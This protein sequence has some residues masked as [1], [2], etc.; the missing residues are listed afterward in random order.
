MQKQPGEVER[1]VRGAAWLLLAGAI[2]RGLDVGFENRPL[3]ALALG[4]FAVELISHR[5]EVRLGGESAL[6]MALRGAALGLA[7]ATAAIIA[8]QV[9]GVARVRAGAPSLSIVLGALRPLLQAGR[10]EILSH[11]M[12]LALATGRIPD[13]FAIPFA[14]LLGAAPLA[15]APGVSLEAFALAVISGGLFALLWRVFDGG[16]LAIGAHAGWS[17]ATDLAIRGPLL[18]VSFGSGA[19]AP[20]AR[21]SGW[22]AMIAASFFAA[23]GFVVAR[24]LRDR[25]ARYATMRA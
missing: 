19:L 15:S 1:V 9:T 22:P 16:W 25:A 18:D 6:R 17:F 3:F 12:P 24:R 4:A 10:D 8:C 23:L 20:A 13:R 7:V 5:V 14:A 11:G 2:V 21:A